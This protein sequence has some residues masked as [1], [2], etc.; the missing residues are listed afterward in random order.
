MSEIQRLVGREIIDSRG[1]PT[2]A[3]EVT[4]ASGVVATA[5]V[6]SGA[7]TG[8][9]EAVELR[10]GDPKRYGGKGVLNAI[11]HVNGVIANAVCGKNV[12]QQ[13]HIDQLMVDLDGTPNKS[14]LGANAVLGVSLAVA[15]AA[16]AENGL[17]LYRYL[18]TDAAHI[19]PVPMINIINGGAHANNNLDVQE[20]MIIPTGAPTFREGL[21]YSVEVFHSLKKLL[22]AGNHSTAVGDEGG[23]APNLSSH[24]EAFHL[25]LQA[26]E[27]AGYDPGKDVSLAI[28]FASSELYQDGFYRVGGEWLTAADMVALQADWVKRYPIISIED[29]MAED[30]QAGWQTLTQAM[31]SQ[32]QLIGDDNFV[33]QA[34]YLQ[35]GIENNV[36]NG[37]LIKL[38]QVGSLT[39]TLETI[40]VAKAADYALVISH[41]S[42]ET[43]DTSIADLAV[44]THAGQIKTGSVCRSERVAKYNR[45]LKIEA[46]LGD[47]AVYPGHAIFRQESM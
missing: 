47:R 38:N 43:C 20:F 15:H 1:N 34:R 3:V 35:Q 25:L 17:P 24:E 22:I 16:A 8:A 14:R 9:R 41:R 46:D 36:A 28:D 27:K 12:N 37:I 13:R 11:Q 45:L 31:A 39:E 32:V 23:F 30:D 7:S 19:M 2:V 4:L 29:G 26:I 10:D 6:P 44:A 5:A 40:A 21:R 18:G 33:T 42:G